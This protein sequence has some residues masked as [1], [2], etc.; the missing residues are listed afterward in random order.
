MFKLDHEIAEWRSKLKAAGIKSPELLDELENHLRETVE[1]QMKSGSKES[2][3]FENAVRQ[4]GQAASIKTEFEKACV[5]PGSAS[6]I[7]LQAFI[8]S[9]MLGYLSL[10]TFGLIKHNM[11]ATE[12]LLGFTALATMLLLAIGSFAIF[13]RCYNNATPL[14]GRTASI[15][16]ATLLIGWF[17][18]FTFIVLPRCEFEITSLVVTL[19]WGLAPGAIAAG[20]MLAKE[21]APRKEFIA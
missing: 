7:I 12:R 2:D 14:A 13:R 17:V 11:S 10:A 3:A 4:M 19:L 1:H 5:L 15:A 9:S 21:E 6:R 20:M 16:S 18:G 8:Y